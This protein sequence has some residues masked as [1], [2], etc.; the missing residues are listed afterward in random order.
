MKITYFAHS[1]FLIEASDGTRIILDPY[2]SGSF[3]GA[4]GYAP[5]GEPADAVIATHTHEDHGAVD[6]VPGSPLV[7]VE[8][9]TATVGRVHVT[10]I[11]VKHDD[12][13][14][15]QRGDMT[16]VLLDDAGLRLLHAGDLGHELDGKTRAAVGRVDVLMIPVGGVFTID[17]ATAARVVA[18]LDPRVVI[19]MHY[20]T[21][22]VDFPIAT[23]EDFVAT[24]EE[25]RR[26]S[27]P[28]VEITADK[29]PAKRTVIVLNRSR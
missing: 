29:L 5:V 2:R 24:Q 23:V 11:A 3:G 25:V 7:M 9:R 12:V 14:G 16:M 28:T 17:A 20:K 18:A 10:G 27:G 15:A 21:T 8:P 13:S 22:A 19:P 1:S 4:F 26:A 6:T